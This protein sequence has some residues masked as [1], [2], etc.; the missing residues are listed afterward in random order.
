[1]LINK[2]SFNGDDSVLLVNG[3]WGSG[4]TTIKEMINEEL[5]TSYDIINYNAIEFE[6][7]SQVTSELYNTMSKFFSL[8]KFLPSNLLIFTKFHKFRSIAQLKKESRAHYIYYAYC[9]I[10]IS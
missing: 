7:K 8:C 3:T 2:S 4:K 1:M 6:E 9:I 10:I 5:K